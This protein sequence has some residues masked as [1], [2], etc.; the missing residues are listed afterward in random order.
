MSEVILNRFEASIDKNK[1]R[2]LM[3]GSEKIIGKVVN[4]E[5]LKSMET[6]VSRFETPFIK[7]LDTSGNYSK[8]PSF[9]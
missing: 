3:A 4:V 9:L 6:Y 5:Q 8:V 2:Y 7:P 1:I